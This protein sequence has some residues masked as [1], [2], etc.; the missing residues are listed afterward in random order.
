MNTIKIN[1]LEVAS[2][3]A[4]KDLEKQFNYDA[5]KIYE[6][7]NDNETKYTETAQEVFDIL[8]DEYYDFL[9]NLKEE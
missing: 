9:F 5:K 2:E 4:H 7:V 6:W 8:Y 3:L 1:I